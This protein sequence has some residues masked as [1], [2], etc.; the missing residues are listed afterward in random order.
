MGQ[1]HVSA[2]AESQACEVTSVDTCC[3]HGG[4]QKLKG[5]WYKYV[6]PLK[7]SAQTATLSL[8]TPHLDQ[9]GHMAKSK[10]NEAEIYPIP[11]G[12]QVTWP[13]VCMG[14]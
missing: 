13:R 6:P 3:S 7:N 2:Y 14:N 11:G 1:L 9:V 10:V 4:G 5:Q 12:R 8:L